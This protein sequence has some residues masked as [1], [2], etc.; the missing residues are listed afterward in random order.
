M[1]GDDGILTE[2]QGE[3]DLRVHLVRERLRAARHETGQSIAAV[4]TE[5]AVRADWMTWYLARPEAFLGAA[6]LV[7]FIVAHRR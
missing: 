4:R 3:Q 1:T 2:V 5:I 6:F 7:G